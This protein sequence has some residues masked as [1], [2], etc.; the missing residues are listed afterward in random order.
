MQTVREAMLAGVVVPAIR[1]RKPG[2]RNLW[3]EKEC[4]DLSAAF[5]AHDAV[6]RLAASV[7]SSRSLV[8]RLAP[9]QIAAIG[10]KGA[11][12]YPERWPIKSVAAQVGVPFLV[13]RNLTPAA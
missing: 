13:L 6:A 7:E 4:A 1:S 12:V 9:H 8:A 2:G 5:D 11:K 10:P 3:T